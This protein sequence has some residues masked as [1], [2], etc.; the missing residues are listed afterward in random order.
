MSYQSD[1]AEAT[2][3]WKSLV[4]EFG[5]FNPNHGEG[6]R[7]ASAPGGSSGASEDEMH[8]PAKPATPE[9]KTRVRKIVDGAKKA[10][11]SAKPVL[12]VVLQI[13]AGAAIGGALGL[14]VAAAEDY[15]NRR[16]R[17]REYEWSSKEEGDNFWREFREAHRNAYGDSRRQQSGESTRRARSTTVETEGETKIRIDHGM[18][19]AKVLAIYIR[20]SSP[21]EKAA[22]A[23]ALQNMGIDVSKYAKRLAKAMSKDQIIALFSELDKFMSD[24]EAEA[25]LEALI[26]TMDQDG[27]KAVVDHA[28][29]LGPDVAK[30]IDASEVAKRWTEIACNL[31]KHNPYHD[32]RT[33]E[34]TDAGHAGNT[35]TG[36][37]GQYGAGRA[38]GDALRDKRWQH[39]VDP[40]DR[41]ERY[42]EIQEELAHIRDDPNSPGAARNYATQLLNHW[43]NLEQ[44]KATARSEDAIDAIDEKLMESV[45]KANDKL[46]SDRRSRDFQA[47]VEEAQKNPEPPGQ[48]GKGAGDNLQAAQAAAEAARAAREA[49]N[50]KVKQEAIDRQNAERAG[51]TYQERTQ[52]FT[53]GDQEAVN[54]EIARVRAA[55]AEADFESN[56]RYETA[57]VSKDT[58]KSILAQVGNT[59]GHAARS[60]YYAQELVRGL[61][62]GTAS[63]LSGNYLE[64]GRALMDARS[65]LQHLRASIQGLSSE[66]SSVVTRSLRAIQRTVRNI[67]AASV[68]N[69]KL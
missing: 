12:G 18:K 36:S 33:G 45:G 65:D 34:F 20:A 37:E 38:F 53:Q 48:P 14:G 6:G 23:H 62:G 5:K 67:G 11:K 44:Q 35:I 52:G 64:A 25:V 16:S 26:E 61:A 46:L 41:E 7:F 31:E 2:R 32:P 69:Q 47:R 19:A 60:A 66:G 15:V 9:Q 50:A 8:G 1:L 43:T 30:R 27:V 68:E 42:I 54:R 51:R 4:G 55:R 3:T 57:S 28:N 10:W 22:A 63:A 29:Q 56:F 39:I 24:D 49:Y 40:E 13:L 17:R 59:L 21:G 58:D